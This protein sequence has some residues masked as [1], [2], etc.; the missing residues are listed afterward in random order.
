M[1]LAVL[2]AAVKQDRFVP[3]ADLI[4]YSKADYYSNPSICYAQGWGLCQFLLHSG[5]KK[6]EKVVPLFVQLVSRDTNMEVVT[7]KAFKGIDMVE[8]E[9]DFLAWLETQALLP[10]EEVADDEAEGKPGDD[11][12]G[13]E[14]GA[15]D[16]S[17]GGQ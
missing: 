4:K 5:N 13:G 17:G 8:L 7:A 15:P 2:K 6:Y 3:L 10:E 16:K 11:K 12:G 9:K 1:R 14:P